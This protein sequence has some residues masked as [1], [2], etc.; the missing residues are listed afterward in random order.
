M[1]GSGL[2]PSMLTT[3]EHPTPSTLRVAFCVCCSPR[4]GG[5]Q[6]EKQPRARY[7][8]KTSEWQLKAVVHN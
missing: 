6:I 4:G 7:E 3:I 2:I 1:Q 8:L 5:N